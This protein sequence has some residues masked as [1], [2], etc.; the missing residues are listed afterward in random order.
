MFTQGT[1]ATVGA[2]STDTPT[3]YSYKT[4]DTI[5]VVSAVGYFDDKRQELD[6][7]DL[8]FAQCVDGFFTLDILNDTSSAEVVTGLRLTQVIRRESDF[9]VSVGGRHPLEA[10][11]YQIDGNV[12]IADGLD[13]AD[14]T[15]LTSTGARINILDYT[16]TDIYIKSLDG[17]FSVLSVGLDCANG[18]LLD[19]ED[20]S[21]PQT[22][23]GTFDTVTIDSCDKLGR[24]KN[25]ASLVFT[26][27]RIGSVITDGINF[28]GLIPIFAYEFIATVVNGGTLFELGTAT[29]NIFD[30]AS[31]NIF[32]GAGTTFISGLTDSGNIVAGGQAQILDGRLSGTGTDL[33]G[34]SVRD[35]ILW[36]FDNINRIQDTNP[37]ALLHF[38]GNAT[39]TVISTINTPVKVNAVW[40]I[41]SESFFTGDTTGKVIY[42]GIKDLSVPIDISVRLFA[43][44]GGTQDVTVYLALNGSIIS[45]SG[46]GV[47]VSGTKGQNV[48]IPWQRELIT[49]DFPEVFVENNS[50]TTNI[51]VTDGI[52]RMR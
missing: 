10:K 1:F 36:K 38:Q 4:N 13:M 35:D 12:T 51:V 24:V 25:V 16:G 27:T 34:V 43:A 9:P 20:I 3:V 18:T 50:G 26:N 19:F 40:T 2:Q 7:G 48:S 11:V 45:G 21:A 15:T 44:G 39:E 17:D 31:F 23:R 29:F 6:L 22:S 47:E 41:D 30:V 49:T 33:T 32:V 37:E 14:G 42:D 28:E 46:R 5:S 52:F 8:I